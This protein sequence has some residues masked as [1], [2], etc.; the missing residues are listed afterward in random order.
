MELLELKKSF[1]SLSSMMELPAEAI[2]PT[3]SSQL[4][5]FLDHHLPDMLH[6]NTKL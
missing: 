6:T 5:K 2:E 3:S 4:S 1:F